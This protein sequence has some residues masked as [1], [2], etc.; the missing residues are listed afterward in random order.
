MTIS[1]SAPLAIPR[2]RGA[3]HA[4]LAGGLGAG[5]IDL[6]FACTFNA[7][8]G[9]IAPLRVVQF[10]AS[11][12]L[13]RAAFAGG[14]ATGVLGIVLHYTILLVAAALFVAVARRQRW[15]AAHPLAAG[16]GC[17]LA[18][19][20]VMHLVVLPLSAAAPYHPSMPGRVLDFLVHVGLI[21]PVIAFSARRWD[22][23]GTPGS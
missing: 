5:T 4:I 6:L 21:G 11:G 18:I 15:L 8:H 12:V 14:L 13:G 19:Y 20:T 1:S 2:R 17:G 10:I 22:L 23:R 7:V 9:G 3:A 16:V